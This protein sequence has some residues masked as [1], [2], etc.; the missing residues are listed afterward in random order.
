MTS[1]TVN[2]VVTVIVKNIQFPYVIA[3]YLL[4]LWSIRHQYGEHPLS[5]ILLHLA[6]VDVTH[7]HQKTAVL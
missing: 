2:V 3:T 6:L 4:D 1:C 5:V 7:V